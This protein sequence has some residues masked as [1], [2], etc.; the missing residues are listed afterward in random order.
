MWTGECSCAYK[1]QR[2]ENPIVKWGWKHLW[3]RSQ[4][5]EPVPCS[6]QHQCPIGLVSLGGALTYP[7]GHLGPCKIRAAYRCPGR[8]QVTRGAAPRPTAPRGGCPWQAVIPPATGRSKGHRQPQPRES[9]TQKELHW[10]QIYRKS[11]LNTN[12]QDI[13]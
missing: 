6:C 1:P 9:S 3:H 8:A 7:C 10:W 13:I 2:Q 5:A 12:R 4:A 11:F